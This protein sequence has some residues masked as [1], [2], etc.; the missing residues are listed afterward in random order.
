MMP[1]DRTATGPASGL[2]AHS[3]RVLAALRLGVRSMRSHPAMA[4][5]FLGATLL[6]GALQGLFIWTLREVL[7][8]I[9]GAPVGRATLLVAAGTVLAVWLLRALSVFASEYC[10]VRLAHRVEIESMWT[11]LRQLL[12]LS[13]RFYDR[14]DQGDLIIAAYH[15]MKG[16]RSATLEVGRLL[17]YVTQLVGLSVAA[18]A[19]DPQLALLGMLVVPL[20]LLPSR[21]LGR[22]VT[23]SAQGE[24]DAVGSLYDSFL[25]LTAGIRVIKVNGAEPRVLENA[26]G[27]GSDIYRHTVRQARDRGISRLIFEVAAGVGIVAIL[28]TGGLHVASGEI[29]WPSLLGL[30]LAMTAVY[31]PVIGLLNLTNSLSA[32]LPNLERV[33]RI[34]NEVPDVADR[35][36][37]RRLR[38]APETLELQGVSFGYGAQPCLSSLSATFHRGETIGIVG[39]SGSGKSTLLALLLRFYDPTAGRILLDG[40]DLRDIRRADLMALSALVLQEPFLFLDT[41]AGNIRVGRPE[42]TMDE[43]VAAATAANV[44]DEIMAMERGYDTL[45]GRSRQARG[46]SGGQKQR[47]C[48][49]AAL[50]RNAPLLFLD[51][52]TSSLDSVSEQLVQSAI[53]RLVTGRTT[54]VVAH[55]LSTLRS[56][57]RILVLDAGHV[58]GLDTHERLLET[59]LTYR[60]LW[61]AQQDDRSAPW[62]DAGR[63]SVL[64]TALAPA[65]R[66]RPS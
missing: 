66:A 40:V 17:L 54:F 12:R 64:T 44:H 47:V 26:R 28:I 20:G 21:A 14:S 43:V 51:E 49:A 3:A 19:M 31:A 29:E 5:A 25:Q 24:R 7:L 65:P 2:A 33:E 27:V 32:V 50:L 45:V 41:I 18:V 1:G 57:H 13:V 8:R 34:M 11:A 9:D 37:A 30:L 63:G 62:R 58:M 59:C 56:A 22:R 36:L 61:A 39:A 55:R 46:L 60:S 16:V 42:A 6:Q 23:T 10:A 35:P 38:E 4:A 15:D 48:I 52:A 53:E